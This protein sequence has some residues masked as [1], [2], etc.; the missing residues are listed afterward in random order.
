M[1]A[2]FACVVQDWTGGSSEGQ[3]GTH[4]A[5]EPS[6]HCIARLLFPVG[7]QQHVSYT[8]T[9]CRGSSALASAGEGP[10]GI[11]CKLQVLLTATSCLCVAV[12]AET[13]LDTLVYV[14]ASGACL[15][16]RSVMGTR[17]GGWQG[18]VQ[19]AVSLTQQFPRLSQLTLGLMQDLSADPCRIQH[20]KSPGRSHKGSCNP[21]L[22]H[23]G[24]LA[25]SLRP[26]RLAW[27]MM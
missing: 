24:G 10:A 12:T 19:H 16:L 6:C 15:L 20:S 21:L 18:R 11:S 17:G 3:P 5:A 26:M 14:S 25:H 22:V 8:L 27:P 23:T 7:T 13:R 4:L 2:Q 9:I 1:H